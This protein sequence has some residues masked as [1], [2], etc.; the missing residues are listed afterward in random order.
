MS[1]IDALVE[2]PHRGN[3]DLVVS[4]RSSINALQLFV[5]HD[6]GPGQVRMMLLTDSSFSA[7]VPTGLC[8]EF[9]ESVP[10][11]DHKA[12]SLATGREIPN[13]SIL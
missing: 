3:G 12:A 10:L 13:R 8:N 1:E 7:K 9:N 4:A 6:P 5:A 2:D 11:S